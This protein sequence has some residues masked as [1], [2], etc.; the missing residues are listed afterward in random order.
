M[1]VVTFDDCKCRKSFWEFSFQRYY[2]F[3]IVDGYTY[4]MK[5]ISPRTTGSWDA[6]SYL[7]TGP[8]F[9]GN[10]PSNFDEDHII[11]S[12]SRFTFV[13]GRT[14]VYCEED[15]Q[16]VEAIQKGYTLTPL[17]QGEAAGP[18]DV[19][20]FPFIDSA[21]LSKDTP[22]PQ[23]F[24]TYVNFIMN[25]VS[26]YS[27]ESEL[28][29]QFNKICVG[30]NMTFNGQTMSRVKYEEINVGVTIGA[31]K[32][33][34]APITEHFGNV[35]DGWIAAINPPIFGTRTVLKGKY[36]TRAFAAKVG[37]YGVD[38]QEAYYPSANKDI[39]GDTL[40]ST[41]NNFTLTFPAGRFP[42]VGE[43]GFWSVTMYRLP[44]RLL[45]QNPI[46]RYSI[47]DRT[48]GLVYANDGSLTLYIQKD[49]PDTDAKAANWLP[50]PDP[51][52]EGYKSGLFNVIMRI[53][54]PTKQNVDS[55]GALRHVQNQEKTNVT[56]VE[57]CAILNISI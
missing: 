15:I 33:D 25:Y 37:L 41:K 45:V 54:W 28:M 39:D 4:N 23:L 12:T 51:S 22:E 38:P 43:A 48:Q 35:S 50:A 13:L 14:G 2:S 17:A 11:T 5:I 56:Y 34:L 8:S 46:D 24:F 19:P 32:I 10:I 47:G 9:N 3:Q 40:N 29:Q 16:N 27:D 30:P 36:A 31:K 21:E 44:E 20:L 6:A 57:K 55:S 49:K 26:V 53:Y 7:I 52:H 42:V 1:K 18:A